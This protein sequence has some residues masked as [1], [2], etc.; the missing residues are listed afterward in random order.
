MH[1]TPAVGEAQGVF[2]LS[3]KTDYKPGIGLATA[4]RIALIQNG[5]FYIFIGVFRLIL[6]GFEFWVN[7]CVDFQDA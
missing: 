3:A 6:V 1:S 7:R 5:D 2:C 4:L